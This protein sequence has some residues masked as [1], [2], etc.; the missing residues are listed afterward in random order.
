MWDRFL[1]TGGRNGEII[2]IDLNGKSCQKAR[3]ITSDK[4]NV[5]E[6]DSVETLR[7]IAEAMERR[8]DTVDLIYLDSWDISKENWEGG[9]GADGAPAMHALKELKAIIS[10]LSAGGIVLV[11]DNMIETHS[12]A[13]DIRE[14]FYEYEMAQAGRPWV[15][16][17]S[18]GV[19]GK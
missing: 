8:G 17:E 9:Q 3:R 11:D 19:R 16:H 4:V 13:D 7:N 6:G 18:V 14:L 2:S 1:N 10:R 5:I 15:Y 12:S